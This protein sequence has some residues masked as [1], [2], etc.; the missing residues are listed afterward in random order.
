[1]VRN[2]KVFIAYSASATDANYCMGLLTADADADLL[3]PQSWTKS[4]EPVFKSSDATS[5]YGP[6]HNSFTTTPDGKTVIM[7]YH[8]RN[9]KEIRGGSLANPD[10]HTRAQVVNWNSD[11]TPDFGV[12]V[13]DGSY[14]LSKHK[15]D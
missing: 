12:P 2:N 6:G 7:V 14:Y 13:P 10:R 5:Q 9:Y 3:D 1:M 8:A 15:I 4:K 11:G